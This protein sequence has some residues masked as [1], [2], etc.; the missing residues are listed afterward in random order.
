MRQ[1]NALKD[2]KWAVFATHFLVWLLLFSIPFFSINEHRPLRSHGFPPHLPDKNTMLYLS[3]STNLLLAIIFYLNIAFIAPLFA[4]RKKRAYLTIQAIAVCLFYLLLQ[5]AEPILFSL[6]RSRPFGIEMFSYIIVV[7]GSLCYGLIRENINAEHIQKENE[8][9]RLNAELTFLRWQISPHFLFN[10]LN[11][12]VALARVRSEKLDVMLINLSSLMRYML[13]ET[14][15][16]KISIE[17]ET[18]YLKSYINLQNLRFGNDVKVTADISLPATGNEPLNTI[19]PMLLIP[20]IENAYKHGIGSIPDPEIIIE[21]HFSNGILTM[22]VK[23]KFL[24]PTTVNE[25]DTKGIGLVN[26]KRRLKLL[27]SN[28]HSLDIRTQEGWYI[29]TLVINLS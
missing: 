28:K 24:L 5:Y 11:N 16:R 6:D 17:Q 26:V 12:M 7:L 1:I 9:E 3:L 20:F 23:N 29:S 8:N 2:K 15:K 13:Y 27:Y 14:D 18:E 25:D 4:Q 10:V 21:I 22:T 19:E